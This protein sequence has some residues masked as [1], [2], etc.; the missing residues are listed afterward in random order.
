VAD[1][2]LEKPVPVFNLRDRVKIR[3]SRGMRGRV[4]ELRGALGPGGSQVYRVRIFERVQP[5]YIEVMEDQ[6]KLLPTKV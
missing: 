6:L 1:Q 2:N 5:T 3:H 4:V